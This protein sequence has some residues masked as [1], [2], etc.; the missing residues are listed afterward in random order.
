MSV[1][2][3]IVSGYGIR[4]PREVLRDYQRAIDPDGE[5][6]IRELLDDLLS[7][8][9]LIDY[10]TAGS[11]YDDDALDYALVIART[12][13]RDDHVSGFFDVGRGLFTAEERRLLN[14]AWFQ[15]CDHNLNAPHPSWQIGGLWS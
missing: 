6:S 4:I 14:R 2:H 12:A 10:I 11:Y 15:L 7:D 1:D 13:T 9:P 8:L 5:C 3:D